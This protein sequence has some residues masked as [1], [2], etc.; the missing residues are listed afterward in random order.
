ME[1]APMFSSRHLR[2]WQRLAA[3]L[4]EKERSALLADAGGSLAE[5]AMQSLGVRYQRFASRSVVETF[6][7]WVEPWLMPASLA[8]RLPD[9][10][11]QPAFLGPL[12]MRIEYGLPLGAGL[13]SARNSI[14]V[15]VEELN[16]TLA[17]VRDLGLVGLNDAGAM[18][19]L[20]AG[21]WQGMYQQWVWVFN[22][23]WLA[24]SE[25]E[26]LSSMFS[27]AGFAFYD[28]AC[29]PLPAPLDEP[30]KWVIALPPGFDLK[31]GHDWGESRSLEIPLGLVAADNLYAME[32]AGTDC[33]RWSGPR[34]DVQLLLPRLPGSVN[35]SI[36]LYAMADSEAGRHARVFVDGRLLE[37]VHLP[38]SVPGVLRFVMPSGMSVSGWSRVQLALPW[39]SR[40]NPEDPRWLGVAL[41][42]IE[43][44]EAR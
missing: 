26:A 30:W 20:L 9:P 17:S 29:T 33:W 41:A 10:A 4:A 14:P 5:L 8:D 16:A 38:S 28:A 44:D 11:V 27:K 23:G 12:P 19:A 2:C 24:N 21:G 37:A 6:G 42:G 3:W 35:I 22:L 39:S 15:A 18:R 36:M 31:N 25:K 43:L 7:V 34:P 13:V 32:T 1:K 40:P